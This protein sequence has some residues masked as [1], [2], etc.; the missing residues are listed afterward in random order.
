LHAPN[1]WTRYTS[2]PWGNNWDRLNGVEVAMID[3]TKR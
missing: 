3:M 1:Q 2:S